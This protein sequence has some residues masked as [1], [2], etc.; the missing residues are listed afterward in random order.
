M[1]P[2]A[3]EPWLHHLLEH[4]PHAT[5]LTE[6]NTGFL[7]QL[8]SPLRPSS[9]TA[10][11]WLHRCELC[12]SATIFVNHSNATNDHCTTPSSPFLFARPAPPWGA[13]FGEALPP[14]TLKIMSLT[15]SSA[16]HRFP[17]RPSA[18]AHQSRPSRH[19]TPMARVPYFRAW[20]ASPGLADS[21]AGPGRSHQPVTPQPHSATQSFHFDLIWITQ[22]DPS[23]P[24]FLEI[25]INYRKI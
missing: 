18:L 7:D 10:C 14:R 20:A 19:G 2:L 16:P 6:T 22:I 9:S 12:T 25:R 1:P 21:L 13:I 24:K 5:V 3:K 23:F 4:R 17:H 15:S 11:P 8:S